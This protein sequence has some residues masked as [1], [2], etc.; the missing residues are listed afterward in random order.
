MQIV[1]VRV[2]GW[3]TEQ[4]QSVLT[5]PTLMRPTAQTIRANFL[6]GDSLSAM[7]HV[8]ENIVYNQRVMRIVIEKPIL[9]PKD[10]HLSYDLYKVDMS[11]T[12]KIQCPKGRTC[13]TTDIRDCPAG[14]FCVAGTS[15]PQDCPAGK[16]CVA[17]TSTPQDCSAGTFS[18]AEASS[19]TPQP[20]CSQ[21][22]YLSGA[23]SIA[24]GECKACAA[25]K[26]SAETGA[27]ACTDCAAGKYSAET[28]ATAC[29]DCAAG[30]Y[31]AVRGATSDATCT[32]CSSGTYST[33]GQ[34][35]CS[36]C[37]AGQYSTAGAS[38]CAE[39]E[40]GFTCI[41]ATLVELEHEG[42]E[43]ANCGGE[44]ARLRNRTITECIDFTNAHEADSTN[45]KSKFFAWGFTGETGVISSSYPGKCLREYCL[46]SKGDVNCYDKKDL[47]PDDSHSFYDLYKV[48]MSKTH[49][50]QC[51]AGRTCT[52]TDI[53]DCP[54]GKILRSWH[55]CSSRLP[56]WKIL[57]SWHKYSSRLPCWPVLRSRS[58]L[59][60]VLRRWP[61]LRSRSKFVHSQ[62]TCS[63][64]S[65]LS[66]ASSTAEGVCKA[67]AADT[68]QDATSHRETTCKD[69]PTCNAG[70]KISADSKTAERTCTACA[71]N[72]YQDA[73]S[74]RQTNCEDQPT[75]NAGQKIS[76]DSNTAKR[77]CSNCGADTYQDA[78]SHRETTCKDQPT[79]NA[80]QKISADSKTAKRTCSACAVGSY[81]TAL[82]HRK[83]TC[84]P[85]QAGYMAKNPTTVRPFIK[86]YWVGGTKGSNHDTK[87][88][89]GGALLTDGNTSTNFMWGAGAGSNKAY[90]QVQLDS[91][92]T[93]FLLQYKCWK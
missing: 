92:K 51:P 1:G 7:E 84:I 91:R 18:A 78:T 37:P 17:G 86:T 71:P 22:S 57:R 9:C 5:S 38:S 76:A 31:S 3:G 26:Y 35:N 14:K 62:A 74:H 58:Q 45:Y 68:Y 72:K 19:C 33:G 40:A 65:Y 67:C 88:E 90:L 46:K 43:D 77:T 85:A 39:C 64:G 66:G 61:V 53:R 73:T 54:A 13:T 52:T 29:T 2:P 6:L 15:T 44:S 8:L 87:N 55:K 69:Q 47:C 60:H 23:S 49:K 30:K 27:T 89:S 63:Q 50:I 25:G 21:G 20:T 79:C 28:G 75:C 82:R 80:G 24:K 12:H 59:L 11:K 10:S 36:S 93:P 41:N 81:Q 56:C 16:F 32:D 42:S 34:E 48:D 4:L 70:Q 83:S